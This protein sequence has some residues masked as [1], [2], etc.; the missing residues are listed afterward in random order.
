MPG[1][2]LLE[3][4]LDRALGIAAGALQIF[5]GVVEFVLIEFEL[6]FGDVDLVLDV[7]FCTLFRGSELV[8]EVG[9]LVL[10]VLDHSG[11]LTVAGAEFTLFGGERGRMLGGLAER[12]GESEIDLVV[13]EA[14]S[15]TGEL[16]F[17]GS[18][19][20][21]GQLARGLQRLLINRGG[22]LGGGVLFGLGGR[23][24]VRAI[25]QEHAKGGAEDEHQ[26]YGDRDPLASS[27]RV[28]RG[29]A[30]LNWVSAN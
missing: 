21:G 5:F 22:G 25:S 4:A 29:D 8:G 14:E 15:L 3:E 17:L 13:G 24:E 20:E 23:G 30:I 12:V 9:D 19:G 7:F 6:S 1:L 11:G 2:V 26:Q 27:H 28:V 18:G 10:I 16:L